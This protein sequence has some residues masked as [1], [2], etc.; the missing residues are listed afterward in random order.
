MID[1]KEAFKIITSAGIT[2]ENYADM[3]TAILSALEKQI[4]KKPKFV[5]KQSIIFIEH[6]D[7]EGTCESEK[8]S[9]WDCPI[10][11]SF[12][13]E[14][15]VPTKHNQKVHNFCPKCGQA[16]DWGVDA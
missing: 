5:C 13:G 2:D 14:Q 9:Q 6:I 10:C 7:G 11:N 4:P 16:I 15:Y 8:F 1:A 12:V 3:H